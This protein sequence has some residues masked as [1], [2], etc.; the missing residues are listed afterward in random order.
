MRKFVG[1][2]AAA[3]MAAAPIAA[4]AQD[5]SALSIR[6]A[7]PMFSGLSLLQDDEESNGGGSTAVILGVVLIVLIGVAA[8]SGSNSEPSNSP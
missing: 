1:L 2:L 3:G 7:A 6:A 8:I 4:S 5:A